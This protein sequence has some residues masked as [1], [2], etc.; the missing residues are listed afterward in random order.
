MRNIFTVD[1]EEWF[2]AN[3]HENIFDVNQSYEVRVLDNTYKLLKHFEENNIYAT[4]FVLGYIVKKHKKLLR[5]IQDA[6]HEIAS[7]G[8]NH[9]LVYTQSIQEFRED[10]Y[11][12]KVLIEDAI[13]KQVKGYRA[14]SWSITNRSLWA[15]DV[16]HELGFIYDSSI[17]PIETFLYGIKDAE[18]FIN[19]PVINGE[20]CSV[21]EIPPSTMRLFS[22]TFA[23]SGGFFLRAFP[24]P[25]IK[26]FTN[27]IND[28]EG[29]PVVFYIHPREIDKHQPK[30]HL[31]PLEYIIHYLN[32]NGCERKLKEIFKSY[33]LTSIE[34]YFNF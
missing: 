20:E 21:F 1:L 17:F 34:K 10:V 3:Y 16:L 9:S 30:L 32:I 13:H 8:V 2:H 19:K 6:G 27:R 4:F 24:L 22:K 31:K 7:H 15:L 18:R 11:Q 5:D 28:V 14:P 29:K 26:A 33:E 25:I 12:S 23:F